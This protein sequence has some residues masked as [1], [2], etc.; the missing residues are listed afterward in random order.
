MIMDVFLSKTETGCPKRPDE[1]LSL[2]S[3]ILNSLFNSTELFDMN[4]YS[5]SSSQPIADGPIT[6]VK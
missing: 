5:M 3:I 1:V 4:K 6:L 2:I